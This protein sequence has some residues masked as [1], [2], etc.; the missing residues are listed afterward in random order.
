MADK[1]KGATPAHKNK[2]GS[3]AEL[4]LVLLLRNE[5]GCDHPLREPAAVEIVVRKHL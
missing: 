4:L 1:E 3:Q 5:L 2:A